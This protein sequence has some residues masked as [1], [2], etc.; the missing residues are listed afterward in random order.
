[1]VPHLNRIS[2]CQGRLFVIIVTI[3]DNNEEQEEFSTNMQF[4]NSIAGNG[5]VKQH[6]HCG[7]TNI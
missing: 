6:E 7:K 5:N 3:N 2:V 1:M 4:S